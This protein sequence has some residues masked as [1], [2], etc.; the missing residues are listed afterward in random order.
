MTKLV[1]VRIELFLLSIS[2]L[3]RSI[4]IDYGNEDDG[5]E[6]G[7]G[8]GNGHG[9]ADD[10]PYG[11]NAHFASTNRGARFGARRRGGQQD[12]EQGK[13]TELED[14]FF[15]DDLGDVDGEQDPNEAME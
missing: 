4:D 12:N 2:S 3:L 9:D 15:I 11:Y 13:T 10:D 8:N 1:L 14:R 5:N 6:N 7:N